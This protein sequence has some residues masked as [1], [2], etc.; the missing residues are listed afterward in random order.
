M[1]FPNIVSIIYPVAIVYERS[2]SW[3]FTLAAAN[4]QQLDHNSKQQDYRIHIKTRVFFLILFPI[5]AMQ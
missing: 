3:N 5:L 2:G 1:Y 4:L